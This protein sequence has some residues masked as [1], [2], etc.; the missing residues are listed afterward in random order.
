ML[1]LKKRSPGP[2]E[3]EFQRGWF[4]LDSWPRGRGANGRLQGE[5]ELPEGVG[6]VPGCRQWKGHSSCLRAAQ[7]LLFEKEKGGLRDSAV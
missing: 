2:S 6:E 3:G 7:S 1:L 5:K 4:G